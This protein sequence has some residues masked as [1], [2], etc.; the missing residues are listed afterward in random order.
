[1][2]FWRMITPK[3]AQA[4]SAGELGGALGEWV[5]APSGNWYRI[6]KWDSA[7]GVA[8]AL[9]CP[10]GLVLANKWLTTFDWSDSLPDLFTGI[11]VG[12]PTED[13][14]FFLTGV[15]D[16][17]TLAI[18]LDNPLGAAAAIPTDGNVANTN[19]LIWPN[20]KVLHG[21]AAVDDPVELD[22]ALILGRAFAD[23]D[24]TPDLNAG[25]IWLPHGFI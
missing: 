2:S 17:A 10:T 24:A 20:D 12:L 25:R 8:P 21:V 19:H 23:D 13:L 4:A 3:V 6:N 5:R 14:P 16:I 9:Y 1:M 18:D 15:G 22:S 11:N 7:D